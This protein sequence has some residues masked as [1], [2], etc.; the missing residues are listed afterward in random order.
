MFY[1]ARFYFPVAELKEF[2][3]FIWGDPSS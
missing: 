3:W 2:P 1:E